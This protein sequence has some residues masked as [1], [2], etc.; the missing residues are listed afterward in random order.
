MPLY[1]DSANQFTVTF[2]DENGTAKDVSGYEFRLEYYQT[3]TTITL[4]IGDGI[5]FDTDGTDGVVE[6]TV[7]KANVNKLCAGAVRVRL[8]DDSGTDPVITHEG[9]DTVEG[10]G[11]DS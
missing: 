1:R 2:L 5:E 6:F 9:S 4:E 7:S 8:F 10:Q 11:F 3:G